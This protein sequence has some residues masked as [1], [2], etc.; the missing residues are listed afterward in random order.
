MC[1]REQDASTTIHQQETMTQHL[2]AVADHGRRQHRTATDLPDLIR[3]I[4]PRHYLGPRA[5][6]KCTVLFKT[7]SGMCGRTMRDVWESVVAHS[8]DHGG[9][10]SRDEAEQSHSACVH[11]EATGRDRMPLVSIRTREQ[12]GTGHAIAE[13][14]LGML[15]EQY[16]QRTQPGR[17]RCSICGPG[18]FRGCRRG[19]GFH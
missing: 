7:M 6:N 9:T 17:V 13:S 1:T 5:A 19:H 3:P 2:H 12:V 10:E 11:R 16:C 18:E 4:L 15:D 8:P 14:S